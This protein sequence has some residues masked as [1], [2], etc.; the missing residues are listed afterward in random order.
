MKAQKI[1]MLKAKEEYEKLVSLYKQ[2]DDSVEDECDVSAFT[3]KKE[4]KRKKKKKKFS[5]CAYSII[6]RRERKRSCGPFCN[7]VSK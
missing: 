5:P 4:E 7:L 1:K 2:K 6:S 3:K